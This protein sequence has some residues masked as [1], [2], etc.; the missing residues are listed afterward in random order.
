MEGPFQD[1][2]AVHADTRNAED[3]YAL[4][5]TSGWILRAGLAYAFTGEDRDAERALEFLHHWCLDPE[6]NMEPPTPQ[7]R[8]AHAW[9]RGAMG[10]PV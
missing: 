9:L 5:D 6:T 3:A 2:D 10:D 1:K 8:P 7:R 4:D